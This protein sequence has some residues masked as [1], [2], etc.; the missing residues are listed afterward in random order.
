MSQYYPLNMKAMVSWRATNLT[1]KHQLPIVITIIII[2]NLIIII[3][4]LIIIIIIITI[5]IIIIKYLVN[6]KAMVSWRLQ[7]TNLSRKPQ[8]AILI[9]LQP[10]Q[11]LQRSF[12]LAMCLLLLTEGEK[13]RIKVFLRN[14]EFKKNPSCHL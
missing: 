5:I 3:N 8:L 13:K 2:N 14:K 11:P 6:M 12:Q 7:P 9:L 4:N 10:D 1:H